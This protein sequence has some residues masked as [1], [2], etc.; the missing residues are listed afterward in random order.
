MILYK[1]HTSKLLLQIAF[2]IALLS[3][4][5]RGQELF[6]LG[7]R[8]QSDSQF[9]E[10]FLSS[11][12]IN[13]ENEPPITELESVILQKVAEMFKVNTAYAQTMLESLVSENTKTSATFNYLL[14]NL[15]FEN[16]EY[17]LAE[18]EYQKAI[19]KFPSF[20]RAW[21]NLGVLLMR[22]DDIE[23]SM[24]AFSKSV[25]LGDTSAG[26][27][28][29]L[30]YC[31]F[32]LGNFLS[33]EAAYTQAIL[34]DPENP[35]WLEGKVQVF[36]ESGRFEEAALMLDELIRRYP[37]SKIYWL[38]QSNAFLALSQNEQA[39]R[40]IELIRGMGAAGTDELNQLGR[41]YA[42]LGLGSL[43]YRTFSELVEK[44]PNSATLSIV[45]AAIA[46]QEKGDNTT[47]KE[48]VSLLEPDEE[49]I[50]EQI[51]QSYFR[52]KASL[53]KDSG[54][55]DSAIEFWTEAL[56]RD[57]LNGEYLLRLASLQIEKGNKAQAY[58]FAERAQLD[59]GSRFTALLLQSKLLVED[60]R[61]DDAQVTLGKALQI[62]SS[63]SLQN[64]YTRVVEASAQLR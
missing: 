13:A 64:L 38:A 57:P 11:Y 51:A 45:E 10:S 41:L 28:G 6:D 26:T 17:L 43:T 14:A 49:N 19:E 52:L 62:R 5:S 35:Q 15:Y 20:Q 27:L 21:K 40:N 3:S 9:R 1:H 18:T 24:Q 2:T 22:G 42:S 29:R 4:H 56:N 32:L 63:E 36:M 47:A 60:R 44:E 55:L 23:K 34:H 37:T 59:E 33:S 30:A 61:F 31:H 39:A 53:A 54:D 58:L 50:P 48:L 7:Y 25:S 12:G 46:L 8:L 16:E